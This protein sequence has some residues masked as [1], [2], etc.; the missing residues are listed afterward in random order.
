MLRVN[1]EVRRLGDGL[2]GK[3]AALPVTT[4]L[5]QT[6]EAAAMSL[7]LGDQVRITKCPAPGLD[8]RV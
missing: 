7:R 5:A 2:W 4:Q 1:V 6:L 3:V 8:I